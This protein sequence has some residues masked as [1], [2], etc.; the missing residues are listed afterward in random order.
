[1]S[2]LSTGA[3]SGNRHRPRAPVADST[4]AFSSSAHRS[5]APSISSRD[6]RTSASNSTHDKSISS[7][8]LASSKKSSRPLSAMSIIEN[9]AL[10][11][12]VGRVCTLLL[13]RDIGTWLP[14]IV[15]PQVYI[16]IYMCYTGKI[17]IYMC[18]FLYFFIVMY[19]FDSCSTLSHPAYFSHGFSS[20][21]PLSHNY[22]LSI[23]IVSYATCTQACVR[24]LWRWGLCTQG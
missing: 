20:S 8:S 9:L 11:H 23:G 12:N 22:S 4:L 6:K 13:G 19:A 15:Q 17:N 7:S 14:S 24:H 3:D 2:A 18:V 16:Y 1:M 21:H 5:H 10:E